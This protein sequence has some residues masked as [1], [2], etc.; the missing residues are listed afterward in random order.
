MEFKVIFR[1]NETGLKR[2]AKIDDMASVLFLFEHTQLK[3]HNHHFCQN[4]DC[5]F[6]RVSPFEKE[7]HLFSELFVLGLVLHF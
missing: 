1:T 2:L 4:K 6:D 5:S 3:Q 7:Y